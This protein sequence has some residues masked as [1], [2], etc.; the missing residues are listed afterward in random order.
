MDPKFV[1]LEDA[2]LVSR[3]PGF[4]AA[5][6]NPL[7]NELF[8]NALPLKDA[9]KGEGPEV[10][11][12]NGDAPDPVELVLP[13]PS[14]S[15]LGLLLKMDAPPPIAPK[16]EVSDPENAANFEAAKAEGLVLCSFAD[17]SPGLV[18][19]CFEAAKDPNGEV[20]EVLEKGFGSVDY[21]N[22]M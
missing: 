16:G 10:A 19:L 3:S 1:G 11:A 15:V 20:A 9:P 8:A 18:G 17:C 14:P 13:S 6:A 2:K 5:A 22:K 12:A 7:A 4:G 21:K